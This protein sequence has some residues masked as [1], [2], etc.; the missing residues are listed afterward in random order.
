MQNET[1]AKRWQWVWPATVAGLIVVAS[2][3]SIVASPDVDNIDKVTHFAVFGL[4]GTL[5]G[6]LGRG[7]KAAVWS[8]LA[9]AAFGALD[10]WHQSYVPGRSPEFADWIADAAGAAVAIALYNGWAGYRRML[11]MKLGQRRVEKPASVLADS[12]R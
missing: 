2:S 11:E 7:W 5:V 12:A 4:I 8:W 1:S 10:E 3:R 6:R 9:V